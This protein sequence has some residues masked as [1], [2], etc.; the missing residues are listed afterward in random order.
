MTLKFH[1]RFFLFL[2]NDFNSVQ[3]IKNLNLISWELE[4]ERLL[5]GHLEE[6]S[7]DCITMI[8]EQDG[9]PLE[10]LRYLHQFC[11]ARNAIL[12]PK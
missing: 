3:R 7:Q 11:T 8:Y 1:R 2:T 12:S 9:E 5:S 10:V 6:S 4:G